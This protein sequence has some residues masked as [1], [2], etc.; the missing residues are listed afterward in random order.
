MDDLKFGTRNKKGDWKP[1]KLSTHVPLFDWPFNPIKILKWLFGIPGY[2]FPWTF[3]YGLLAI[4]IWVYFTPSLSA[5][6]NFHYDWILFILIRNLIITIFFAGGLHFFLYIKKTQGNLFKFNA[7]WMA[8]N[9]SNFYFKDQTLDNIFWTLCSGVPIWTAYE[10]FSLWAFSNSYFLTLS[11]DIHPIY[12]AFT[13]LIIPLFREVHFYFIHRLLH[14]PPLYNWSHHIHHKN[15]NP[16]PWSGI[17]MHWFEHCLYFTGTLIHFIVPAHPVHAVFQLLH[18]GIGPFFHGHIGFDKIKIGK[19][20][21]DTHSHAHYLH[22]K[23]FECNYADGA[24]PLDR[25][26]GTF[27]DGSDGANIRMMERLQKRI[28]KMK[29]LKDQI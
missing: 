29:T 15:V 5:M 7:K 21:I 2:L 3:F 18:A 27:H 28:K 19:I 4:I 20:G 23:Y 25:M 26:F 24:V 13:F 10:V 17:A 6:K 1:F 22:H 16:G 14:W 9:N 11:W 12:L 8:K